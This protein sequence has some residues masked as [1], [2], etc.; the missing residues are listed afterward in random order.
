[1]V[2]KNQEQTKKNV[3]IRTDFLNS[4]LPLLPAMP[5]QP[6]LPMLP[7]K[8][9]LLPMTMLMLPPLKISQSLVFVQVDRAGIGILSLL[10][11][12]LKLCHGLEFFG[13]HSLKLN[14]CLS[15]TAML[16]FEPE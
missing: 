1:M 12:K 16:S 13:P 10:F 14:Q 15:P 2:K 11:L 3:F 7:V 9:L 6:R 8:P 5:R 4:P